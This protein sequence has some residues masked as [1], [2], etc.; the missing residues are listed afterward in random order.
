S[1]QRRVFAEHIAIAHRSSKALVI[2]TRDAWDDTFA[3]LADEGVPERVVFHCWT[4]GPAEAERAVGIGAV[5][6]F[7]GIVTFR[8]AQAVREAAVATPL[9]RIAVETDSPFLTPV[10]HRGAR[11]EPAYVAHVAAEIAALK[12]V[13]VAEVARATTAA[14]ERAFRISRR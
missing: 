14:A 6:S 2:H 7:S 10:P 8:N 11:N 13:P 9:D 12:G 4:G 5:L 3:I 1:E